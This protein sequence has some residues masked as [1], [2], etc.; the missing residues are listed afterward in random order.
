MSLEGGCWSWRVVGRKILDIRW[1]QM[2]RCWSELD[3]GE[4]MPGLVVHS[5]VEDVEEHEVLGVINVWNYD[6]C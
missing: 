3:D 4:K 2:R 6:S 5:V 1:G